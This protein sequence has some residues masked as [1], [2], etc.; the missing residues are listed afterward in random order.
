[1]SLEAAIDRLRLAEADWTDALDAH[2]YAEPNPGFAQRLRAIA[3]A[4]ERQQA[5]FEYAA[6][7]RLAWDPLPHEPE[8]R[9]APHELSPDSGR[10]GPNELWERFD[11]AFVAWDR[12]LEQT[13][14]AEIAREFGELAAAARELADAVDL[15]R[16]VIDPERGVKQSES[17]PSPAHR[18]SA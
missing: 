6:D 13:S 7:E 11:R 18:Q 5:A 2:L 8:G 15:E 10:V 12:S 1:M 17:G 16:G 3:E 9:P 14:I 4:A